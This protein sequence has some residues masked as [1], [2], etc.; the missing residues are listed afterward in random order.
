MNELMKHNIGLR[1]IVSDGTGSKFSS[2]LSSDYISG[3]SKRVA[4]NPSE[5]LHEA[6]KL[7][8]QTESNGFPIEVEEGMVLTE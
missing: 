2:I 3:M 8:I 4:M 7:K 1:I 6:L 5:A